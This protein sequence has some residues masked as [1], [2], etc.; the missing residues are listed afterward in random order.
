MVFGDI[1]I[2]SVYRMALGSYIDSIFMV[3]SYLVVSN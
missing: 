3:L 1:I 2:L